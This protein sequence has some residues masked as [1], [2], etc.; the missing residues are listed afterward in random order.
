[1]HW[2]DQTQPHTLQPIRNRRYYLFSWIIPNSSH[3]WGGI[4]W[5]KRLLR[6]VKPRP[7]MKHDSHYSRKE[8]NKNY[9]PR[10]AMQR[11]ITSLEHISKPWFGSKLFGPINDAGLNRMWLDNTLQPVLLTSPPSLNH[12]ITWWAV[13]AQLG[14]PTNQSLCLAMW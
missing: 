1:M 8:S 2:Q 12:A 11:G 3:S 4:L 6:I 7:Q 13:L 9:Y 5:Q 14:T 10:R